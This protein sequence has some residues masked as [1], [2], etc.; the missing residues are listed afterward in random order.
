MT[1]IPVESSGLGQ[2]IG[3]QPA[4]IEYLDYDFLTQGNYAE[5][6]SGLLQGWGQI[7]NEFIRGV[8][9][10]INDFL[11]V[12]STGNRQL[13]KVVDNLGVQLTMTV[14]PN[15]LDVVKIADNGF[16]T[17]LVVGDTVMADKYLTFTAIDA[18]AGELEATLE[19]IE[20]VQPNYS[21]LTGGKG[22]IDVEYIDGYFCYI[23][24]GV[25]NTTPRVFHSSLKTVNF[26]KDIRLEDFQ[27][28]DSRSLMSAAFEYRGQLVVSTQDKMYFYQN[29]GNT[30][31]AFQL[32]KGQTQ[33]I[34]VWGVS[35]YRKITNDIA[36]V[37][38]GDNGQLGL[39]ILGEGKISNEFIDRF[40]DDSYSQIIPWGG[41]T[42][43]QFGLTPIQFT[44][45]GR[46]YIGLTFYER[47]I[48][49]GKM[50]SGITRVM[51]RSTN[52]WHRRETKTELY[53]TGDLPYWGFDHIYTPSSDAGSVPSGRSTLIG[54]GAAIDPSNS[55]Q[56]F[57]AYIENSYAG[58]FALLNTGDVDLNSY[59]ITCGPVSDL[60]S[61]MTISALGM[62]GKQLNADI[63]AL[64][65]EDFVNYQS[66]GTVACDDNDYNEW[67]R[68]GGSLNFKQFKFVFSGGDRVNPFVVVTPYAK[69]KASDA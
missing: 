10:V 58:D 57:T 11:W 28:L 40:I 16:V 2:I 69:G 36:F 63:E 38:G 64:Q 37:G 60:P 14:N 62:S 41:T 55:E 32:L 22:A 23:T 45:N 52:I 34:G 18:G 39:Y 59:E 30:E 46:N 42:Q 24:N 21:T 53:T 7:S 54:W 5:R 26:G 68:L 67:R 20:S 8:L 31:F 51:D 25:L 43:F 15:S 13:F 50:V 35:S 12:L 44:E 27:D 47:D 17:V 61:V 3:R 66:L 29:V 4:S 56:Y 9:L 1:P 19:S 49:D 33:D 48:I 65:T 6:P